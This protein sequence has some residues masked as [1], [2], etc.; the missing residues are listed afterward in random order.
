MANFTFGNNGQ[1]S[2]PAVLANEEAGTEFQPATP[3]TPSMLI[4]DQETG[5]QVVVQP[6]DAV[7][8]PLGRYTIEVVE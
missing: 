8:L 3:A 2:R 4:I 1:Q 7:G 5:H 6:G